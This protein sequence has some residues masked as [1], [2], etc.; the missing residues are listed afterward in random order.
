MLLRFV[1]RESS[2]AL[3]ICVLLLW[4]PLPAGS[5]TPAGQLT[6]RLMACGLFLLTMAAR[7][8][9]QHRPG[10]LPAVALSAVAALGFVQSCP[11][12][13][14]V[15]AVV[16]PEHAR[17]SAAAAELG[18]APAPPSFVRLSLDAAVAR[19]AALSWLANAALLAAAVVAGRRARHRRWLLAALAT[20]AIGQIGFG[21]L[22][23]Q[24]ES[25]GGLAAVL[26]RPEG[27]LRGSFANP[28]HLALLL[29][30]AMVAVAAWGW[31]E[32]SSLRRA[33]ARRRAVALL[34]PMLWLILAAGVVLTGSRAGL[35]AALLGTLVQAAALPLAGRGRRAGLA[36]ALVSVLG[37]AALAGLGTKLEIRRYA[38]VSIFE[39]NLRSRVLVAAPALRLWRRFPVTGTG[40]GTFEDAFPAVATAELA[41]VHWNRA[42][43]DPLELLVTG[44]AVGFAL[45][46]L[47]LAGLL[48]PIWRSWRHGGGVEERAAGLAA[49]GALAAAGLHELLDF[50]LV[51]PANALALLTVLGS[52]AAVGRFAQPGPRPEAEPVRE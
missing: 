27:R 34:P 9:R 33:G 5:V 22:R 19:S 12:P 16:S 44:G 35:A 11:W 24:T 48:P 51:I 15:A 13:A 30:I 50:G 41:P 23:L 21:L 42:H 18:G 40:L 45:G 38:T 4:A 7:A 8:G 6:F 31:F 20:A 25:A 32:L 29:E 36:V 26:L 37:L 43:N 10:M 2:I 28:N 17:L 3:A 49:L 47:V 39:T 46:L 14:G 52:A 1:G